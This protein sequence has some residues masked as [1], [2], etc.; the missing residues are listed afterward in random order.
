[1]CIRDRISARVA[2]WA[3][4]TLANE[5]RMVDVSAKNFMAYSLNML[6]AIILGKSGAANHD[7]ER[8]G[9][10]LNFRNIPWPSKQV[11]QMFHRGH[12]FLV[13]RLWWTW[14]ERWRL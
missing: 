7:F 1:M 3:D 14:D 5:T 6:S 8:A 11:L 10:R 4:A 2:S 13:G 9:R 12:C